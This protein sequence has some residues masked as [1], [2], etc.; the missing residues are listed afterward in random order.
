MAD[1]I[2]QLLARIAAA[3]GQDELRARLPEIER[4]VRREWGGRWVYVGRRFDTR[5]RDGSIAAALGAG[6]TPAMVARRW[7]LSPRRIMQIA[8]KVR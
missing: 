5:A 6:Q 7:G 2:T 3:S 8:R 4:Q 1:L